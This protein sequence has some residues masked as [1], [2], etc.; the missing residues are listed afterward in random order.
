M[1]KILT[2]TIEICLWAIRKSGD[3]CLLYSP[4]SRAS[5]C[6]FHLYGSYLWLEISRHPKAH[7][8]YYKHI[9]MHAYTHAC[10]LTI[11]KIG[12]EPTREM[13]LILRVEAEDEQSMQTVTPLCPQASWGSLPSIPHHHSEGWKGRPIFQIPGNPFPWSLPLC[14]TD[15]FCITACSLSNSMNYSELWVFLSI[16]PI[17]AFLFMSEL[18]FT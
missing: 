5:E 10:V 8:H 12:E 9:C 11:W 1:L 17:F 18:P 14:T 7:L 13:R 3:C 4:F 15:V 6:T 2:T 16:S